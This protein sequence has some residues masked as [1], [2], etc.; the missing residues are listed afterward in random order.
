MEEQNVT[1]PLNQYSDWLVMIT[2]I[3]S[4]RKI[5]TNAISESSGYTELATT[6]RSCQKLLDIEEDDDD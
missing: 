2:K 4:I 6:V 5:L 1:I 3:D